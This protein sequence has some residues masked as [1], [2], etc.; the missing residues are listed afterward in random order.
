MSIHEFAHRALWLRKEYCKECIIASNN[1]NSLQSKFV[2]VKEW[3]DQRVLDILTIQET[4]T[5]QAY[6]NSQLQV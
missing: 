5:D 6:P 1:I 4:K 3:L 2:E